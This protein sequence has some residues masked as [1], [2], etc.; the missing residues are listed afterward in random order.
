M[1]L[2]KIRAITGRSFDT[3]SKHL[4][5]KNNARKVNPKGRPPATSPSMFK[6]L[7]A[8]HT[9]MIKTSPSKE[10]TIKAVKAKVGLTCS[11]RAVL[12]AFHKRGILYIFSICR[13]R[14][15]T[16][17]FGLRCLWFPKPCVKI[18]RFSKRCSTV[19]KKTLGVL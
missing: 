1:G 10:V 7:W 12:D 11:D 9:K 14:S 17:I 8:A 2:R 18:Q 15:H 4:F 13:G 6:R 3:I 19:F 16:N 5:K